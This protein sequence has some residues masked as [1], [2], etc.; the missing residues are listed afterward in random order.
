MTAWSGCADKDPVSSRKGEPATSAA[1]LVASGAAGGSPEARRSGSTPEGDGPTASGLTGSAQRVAGVSQERLL[2]PLPNAPQ[3]P[4]GVLFFDDFEDGLGQWHL[5]ATNYFDRIAGSMVITDAA[6]FLGSSSSLFEEIT[7]VGDS[8]SDPIAVTPGETYYLHVAYMTQGGSMYIGIEEYSDLPSGV[9]GSNNDNRIAEHW[10]MGPVPST[11][12]FSVSDGAIRTVELT[13]WDYDAN[14]EDIFYIGSWNTYSASY[15]IPEGT[16]YISIKA[17]AFPDN[18]FFFDNVEWSINPEPTQVADPPMPGEGAE[19]D[20]INLSLGTPE[21]D[22]TGNVSINGVVLPVPESGP[23]IVGIRWDWGD[24]RSSRS[25][26]PASHRYPEV[27][28][29]QV[30]VT[31]V[32]SE[33]GFASQ[34]VEVVIDEITLPEF[35]LFF[36]SNRDDNWEV[37]GMLDDGSSQVNLT[38]NS[39]NDGHLSNTEGGR[40]AVSPDGTKIAF[41]SDR[42]GDAEIFVMNVDGTGLVNLTQLSG[43]DSFPNWS[44]DGTKITFESGGDIYV[45]DADGSNQ[46][47]LDDPAGNFDISPAFSPDGSKIAFATNRDDG[48]WEIYLM[49]ADGS[50][51]VNLSNSSDT[52]E[53][54]PTFSPDGTKIVFES[55]TSDFGTGNIFVMDPDGSNQV[56]I[57]NAT[58][59]NS[60]PGWSPDGTQIAFTSDRDSANDIFVMDADGSNQVNVTNSSSDDRWVDW[61][62]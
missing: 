29:Y 37:Y 55:F 32:N 4:Q 11:D 12:D 39:A 34:T 28:T 10:M 45:M 49:D 31:A 20:R 22:I 40:P 54:D 3:L 38:N 24:A 25:F 47:S 51:Q 17:E 35:D 27:G 16:N 41:T 59:F 15:T 46:V 61:A 21:V 53:F 33:G 50:N 36:I 9:I 60:W 6:A 7:I 62:R 58:G 52:H 26:F 14:G 1:K 19:D 13:V 44:S 43:N 8:W 5:P 57:S 23:Q 48:N 42:F 30:E 2:V 18:N 56:N